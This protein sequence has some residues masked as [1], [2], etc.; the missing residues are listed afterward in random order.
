MDSKFKRIFLM[1]TVIVPFAGYCIYYYAHM[2]KN[3]P[4]KFTEFESMTIEYGPGDS[5]LNKYNSKT[6]EY[7]FLNAKDSLVKMNLHLPKEEL[8]YLHH[9]AAELGF[10]DF[11]SVEIGDTTA[12]QANG[13]KQ[14][15]YVIA[16]NYKRKSKKVIYDGSYNANPRLKDANEQMIK[17]IGK[18]LDAEQGK[19]RN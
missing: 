15:R 6:G 9:K 14:M 18:V 16:F 7:Q 17:E 5:L 13:S 19:H 10:W 8:L 3:A 12:K 2:F 4:Y 1:C 11:P